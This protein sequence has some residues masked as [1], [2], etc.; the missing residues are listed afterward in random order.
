MCNS[1]VQINS[2][3]EPCSKRGMYSLLS[4]YLAMKHGHF[5]LGPSMR[6]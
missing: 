2:R 4:P 6:F 5:A 1:Y 3:S